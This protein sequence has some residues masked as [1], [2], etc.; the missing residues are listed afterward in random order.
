[1]IDLHSHIL[2]GIDD[3]AQNLDVA[4]AMARAAVSGGVRV[5]ACTPH[6]MPGVWDNRGP[7]IRAAVA[8][9]QGHLDEAGIDLRLVTGADVHIVPDL[10]GGLRSG[11]L[12][13]LADTRYVLLEAPHH[14]APARIDEC[15]FGLLSAGYVPI[16]THPERLSW[17]ESHYDL[18]VRLVR[19]GVW[20]QITA[21]SLTGAFGRRPQYWGERMLA[22]GLVHI[23]ASDTHNMTR[24]PPVLA[25][26]RAAAAAI[27]G[28]DEAWHMVVT[29]PLGIL[30]NEPSAQLPDPSLVCAGV[31][32]GPAPRSSAS[33]RDRSVKVDASAYG[34]APDDGLAGRVRR[35]LGWRA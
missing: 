9:L 6:I 1:M 27:V 25:E 28:E 11:R 15:F 21:G 24:R 26:G 20:M 13:S 32:D 33:V 17:I 22:D 14:V 4:L 16:F 35:L 30:N 2:P 18:M 7:D 8:R 31:T 34:A 23:L 19:S 5:Q 12:L 3:G 10:V 29:R